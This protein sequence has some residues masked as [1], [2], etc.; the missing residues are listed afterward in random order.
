MYLKFRKPGTTRHNLCSWG[1]INSS[2]PLTITG[3]RKGLLPSRALLPLMKMLSLSA[4]A[5]A[6]FDMKGE[7][8]K[9]GVLSSLNHYQLLN[10]YRGCSIF[11]PPPNSRLTLNI[12]SPYQLALLYQS[13]CFPWYIYSSFSTAMKA[14]ENIKRIMEPVIS[15]EQTKR[16]LCVE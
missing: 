1:I 3:S 15:H 7:E 5:L 13:W 4:C 10:N 6:R 8:E 16:I 9:G 2:T 11:S 14:V 12:H